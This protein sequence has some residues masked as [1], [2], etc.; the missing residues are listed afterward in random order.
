MMMRSKSILVLGMVLLCFCGL[1]KA[2]LKG[3]YWTGKNGQ[4]HK[5][6]YE[7]MQQ[8]A[9]QDSHIGFDLT[10]IKVSPLDGNVYAVSQ[11]SFYKVE[12]ELSGATTTISS[13]TADIL[14]FSPNG[15]LYGID[16]SNNNL[17]SLDIVT[18]A[19][20]E[21]CAIY[22]YSQF[23]I[24][25]T[26]EAIAYAGDTDWLYYFNLTTGSAIS[27]GQL[28]LPSEYNDPDYWHW[29]EFDYGPD[30]SLYAW[31]RYRSS[32]YGESRLYTVDISTLSVTATGAW[33]GFSAGEGTFAITPEIIPE[34]ATLS[35]ILLG[36]MALA[37][38]RKQI[39]STTQIA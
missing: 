5:V 6:D 29:G 3:Y 27:I 36:G 17:L 15:D 14:A 28:P 8:S 1:A 34:P 7:T 21:I 12:P 35:L 4:V 39:Q 20:A 18:G 38:R 33:F 26:G 2:D 30:G 22:P 32:D 37:K 19:E 10:A 24:G 16:Q 25:T 9:L 11:G 31:C 13:V 23:V